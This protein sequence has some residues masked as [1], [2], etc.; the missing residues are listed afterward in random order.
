MLM[1]EIF[2]QPEVSSP[3]LTDEEIHFH[4]KRKEKKLE[5]GFPVFRETISQVHRLAFGGL[6]RHVAFFATVSAAG[7]VHLAIIPACV[8]R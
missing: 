1:H 6:E 8:N 7:L 2:C 4:K 5:P 3:G